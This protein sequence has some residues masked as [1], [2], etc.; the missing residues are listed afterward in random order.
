MKRVLQF[1]LAGL[2]LVGVVF[3]Q[4]APLPAGLGTPT[5]GS[6]GT[7][8]G[9]VTVG[10]NLAVTGTSTHTGATTLTGAT[11]AG[12]MQATGYGNAATSASGA[13]QGI[14]FSGSDTKINTP[15]G[16]T[17]HMADGSG[18]NFAKFVAAGMNYSG[19]SDIAGTAGSGTGITVNNTA[20]VRTFV[21]KITVAETALTA[22]ATTQDVTLWT[23]AAK[24]KITRVIAQ[25]TVGFTGGTI[26]AATI[27]CGSAAGGAQYI[28]SGSVF[29]ASVLGDVVAE[30]GAGLVSAT[31]ADIPSFS[32][33]TDISCRF[34]TVGDDVVNAT[35][36]SVTFYI[37]GS[38]YP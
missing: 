16:F 34:T 5:L 30:I 12:A 7:Y 13:A 23:V 33:T 26:A 1:G 22:A 28:L 6:T 27:T 19:V 9:N 8:S 29:A 38:V 37:E 3:A 4:S 25:T 36:G 32:T 20:A 18:N 11:V 2:L 14:S 31:L 35:A 21:H 17:I 10:G 15:A 24:T